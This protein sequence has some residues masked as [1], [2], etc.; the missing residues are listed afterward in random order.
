MRLASRDVLQILELRTD[1]KIVRWP[2]RYADP[3]GNYVRQGPNGL[4]RGMWNVIT[5][6]VGLQE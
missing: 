4:E 1:A 5:E 3:R 2:N 6:L